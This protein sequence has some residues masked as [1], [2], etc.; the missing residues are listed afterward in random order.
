MKYTLLISFFFSIL[1]SCSDMND[2]HDMY[3]SEGEDIY[4]GKFDSLK[5]FPG[6]ERIL[7]RMWDKDPRA[8][9]ALVYWYPFND[10][11]WVTLNPNTDS[12]EILIEDLNEGS[13]TF[14][15]VTYDKWDNHSV[16]LEKMIKI[17]GD[18]YRSS[19]S[20]R[21][22][23]QLYFNPTDSSLTLSFAQAIIDDE[24]GIELSYSDK[25]GT[26]HVMYADNEQITDLLI[27]R[28]IDTK[29]GLSCRSLF[30]P[31]PNSIDTFRSDFAPIELIQVTNVALNKP[32]LVSGVLGNNVGTNAVDGDMTST[33][34]RWVSSGVGDHWI[35]IDLEHQYDIFSF[36]TWVTA[37]IP[38]PE[39]KF[40]AE[41]EG[42]WVNV[43]EVTNNT[44][45]NYG[46]DF[47][48]ITTSKVRF[49]APEDVVDYVRLYEIAVYA[50]VKI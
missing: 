14:N 24:I 13:Y 11:I 41:I 30:L 4:I 34:S 29:Q 38:I 12:T 32:V 3:L 5:A 16:I 42:Q 44:N 45:P 6:D 19:L 26:N 15:F 17:Y 36:K 25:S 43:V 48:E 2:S 27:I 33:S 49:F 20:S 18:K 21:I 23:N 35:E 28:N 10:S 31:E 37:Q 39:F 22:L 8:K 1:I 9:T 50:R 7:F 47:P 46:S 40:Q